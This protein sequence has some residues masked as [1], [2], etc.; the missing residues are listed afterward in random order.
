[1]A[2]TW[3]A[4]A[5]A[6]LGVVAVLVV[7]VPGTV[8][9]WAVVVA[10]ACAL[11]TGL[12]ASPRLVAVT[13]TVPGSVRLTQPA[14]STLTV[15]NVGPRRLRA[16]VRDAWQPSA[17]GTSPWWRLEPGPATVVVWSRRWSRRVAA[18]GTPTV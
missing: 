10:L 15:T 8:L 16:T 12:A 3:R 11:D 6:A 5:L 9:L 18:T 13:R 14:T 17:G 2:I 1:V 7:P 4:V